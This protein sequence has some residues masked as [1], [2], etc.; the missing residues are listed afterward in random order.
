MFY[1]KVSNGICEQIDS[2]EVQ[3]ESLNISLF[4]NDTCKG[5]SVF[6]GVT[7]Q[8]PIIPTI[9]LSDQV[10]YINFDFGLNILILG[11]ENI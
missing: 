6:V 11:L 5:G 3:A 9:I 2:V 4:A 10:L 1:V 7:N 8:N